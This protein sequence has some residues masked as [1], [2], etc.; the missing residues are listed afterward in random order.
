MKVVNAL[1]TQ[2]H[3]LLAV[4]ELDTDNLTS[5]RLIE[6]FS[7][8]KFIS[9]LGCRDNVPIIMGTL[10]IHVLSSSFGEAF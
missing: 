3:C 6:A 2:F 7:L 5:F 4:T 10:D 8:S 1:S 9:L